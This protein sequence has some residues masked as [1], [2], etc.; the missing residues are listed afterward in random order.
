MTTIAIL[1]DGTPVR[2]HLF[3][4][5]IF[6]VEGFLLQFTTPGLAPEVYKYH[7]HS[8]FKSEDRKKPDLAGYYNEAIFLKYVQNIEPVPTMDTLLK[9]NFEKVLATEKEEITVSVVDFNE[10]YDYFYDEKEY[11][12]NL[13][14]TLDKKGVR[15]YL[16][17]IIENLRVVD[18]KINTDGVNAITIHH[19]QSSTP[20]GYFYKKNLGDFIN[21]WTITNIQKSNFKKIMAL[22]VFKIREINRD[23]IPIIASNTH[24]FD[25]E[26]KVADGI[27]DYNDSTSGERLTDLEKLLFDLKRGWGYYYSTPPSILPRPYRDDFDAQFSSVSTYE[28]YLAYYSSLINFYDK[29]YRTKNLGYYPSDKKLQYLLEILTP[30]G[31]SLLPYNLIRETIKG[32]LVGKLSEESQR[33]LVRL[34]MSITPAH[35]NDFLDFL[36]EKKNGAQTNFETIYETLTDGRLERYTFVNWFVDEQTN[37][38]YFAF[39]IF[40]LWKVSKYNL[41]Y[42][43]PGVTPIHGSANFAGVDPAGYFV[44]NETDY[45]KNNFLDYSSSYTFSNHKVSVLSFQSTIE[46]KKIKIDKLIRDEHEV[47]IRKTHDDKAVFFGSFHLYQQISFS[48][49]EA[50]LDLSIPKKAT[51]PAFLFHFIEEFDRIADFDAKVSLAI[52]LTADVLLAYFT[53]GAGVV[54]DLHYLKHTTKIGRALIGSLEATEAVAV[55]RGLEVGSEVFTL[56]AGSLAQIN[57]YLV[58]TENNEDKRKVFQGYQKVL[59]PL[60]FLGAGASLSARAHATREA[61]RVLNLI[62]VLPSGVA[63]GLSLDAINLLNTLVGHKTVTLTTFGNRLNNLDLGGATNTIISKYNTLFTDAQKLKFWNDFQH[64][65]DPA[66]WKLLNSGKGV[67]NVLNGKYIDNWISL[68]ERGLSEAK[69]TDYICVQKRANAIVR[70]VDEESIIPVLG[71]LSY[72]R[73][74]AFLDTFGDV[75]ATNFVK[76]VDE[77]QLITYW[78]RYYDDLILRPNFVSL[79]NTKKIKWLEKYGDLSADLYNQYLK[80]NPDAILSWS[81]YSDEADLLTE[82]NKFTKEE[83]ILFFSAFKYNDLV[84][85]NEFKLDP[86]LL[87]IQRNYLKAYVEVKGA[88][89]PFSTILSEV[90]SVYGTQ[91]QKLYIKVN[92]EW[93]IVKNSGL[94][95]KKLEDI[96]LKS[97]FSHSDFPDIIALRDNISKKQMIDFM[98]NPKDRFGNPLNEIWERNP[99]SPNNMLDINKIKAIYKKFDTYE[100]NPWLE[101]RLEVHLKKRITNGWKIDIDSIGWTGH[102][103]GTHAEIRAL[104]ELLWKLEAEGVVINDDILTKILGYN[105]NYSKLG[106]IMPRCGDC[107]FM[108][109]EIR[110]IMSN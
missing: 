61:E 64:I 28:D 57:N 31:L 35:A 51:V 73:K 96:V 42:I 105:R 106:P 68:S 34:V 102:I 63:H 44:I 22:I 49:F 70:F 2:I 36:L 87:V 72:E 13:Q 77:P 23:I 47:D 82:L 98:K 5:P 29:C 94:S 84:S 26:N 104:N 30:S 69:F 107:L 53:G 38:K 88:G 4:N 15:K 86:S 78:R 45:N 89:Y 17:P 92:E 110:M 81:K 71:T 59:I 90:I 54:A 32:Y 8:E 11:T 58:T 40:E 12:F 101:K 85:F 62:D 24:L 65:D 25:K 46:G 56:T 18:V 97:G 74:L 109:R 83:Q 80:A 99:N 7:Q 103:P 93:S 100:I 1:R 20:G 9:Y 10:P 14:S 3:D 27:I 21:T 55:W 39:A 75:D 43:P 60:I 67:D 37:K 66:F 50:N 91:G 95:N 76:F 48:G 33:H 108:S 19:N 52:E 16:K 41:G 6:D 79:S